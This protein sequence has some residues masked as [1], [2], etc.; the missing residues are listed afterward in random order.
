MEKVDRKRRGFLG[1]VA[2]GAAALASLLF[3][4]KFLSPRLPA[5]SASFSVPAAEVP[6]HGALVYNERRVAV[7]RDETGYHAIG[8]SC[9]HLGCTVAVTPGELVC[10]CH[11]SVFDRRGNV[12]KGPA[13][14]PLP[15]YA[16]EEK[17]DRL[18]VYL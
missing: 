8:L 14:K 2:A 12:L 13:D 5:K 17:G 4:R 15:R 3:L 1:A 7:I 6:R 18:L 10:P 16:V 11:G 9:T